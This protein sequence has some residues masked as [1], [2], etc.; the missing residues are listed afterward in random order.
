[1][2]ATTGIAQTRSIV[3]VDRISPVPDRRSRAL[4]AHHVAAVGLVSLRAVVGMDRH[5]L[6][7]ISP[8]TTVEGLSGRNRT[9]SQ[10]RHNN[11][12][13]GDV[14][15]AAFRSISLT[16]MEFPMLHDP[17]REKQRQEFLQLL[18]SANDYNALLKSLARLNS[19]ELKL[20]VAEL[21]DQQFVRLGVWTSKTCR[22]FGVQKTLIVGGLMHLYSTTVDV[23]GC[24]ELFENLLDDIGVG[25]TQAY[26]CR[27]AW[28]CFGRSLIEEPAIRDQ[29]VSESLK[30]LSEPKAS[31]EARTQALERA[32]K[33]E[34]ITIRIAKSI[35][36]MSSSRESIEDLSEQGVQAKP[37]VN[38][39]PV[40]SSIWT[41]I[42]HVSKV[43][44]KPASSA[45]RDDKTTLIRDLE[46][47]ISALSQEIYA[48][49]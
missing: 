46:G 18:R 5:S 40:G 37:P 25:K 28:V 27:D 34:R 30:L 36:A 16:V 21:D 32:R 35:L 10:Y 17:Q 26:R 43:T 8:N 39:R 13:G 24:S 31:D 3:A 22:A 48:T 20:A 45:A 19:D 7:A 44:V 12:V 29:F 33:G 42:G 23:R 49:T 1:M 9:K 38:S 2:A 6:V 4:D 47:A 41:F 15:P 11:S 14:S